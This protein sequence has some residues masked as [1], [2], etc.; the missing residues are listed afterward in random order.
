MQRLPAI[1][2]QIVSL[3][4]NGGRSLTRAQTVETVKN[5]KLTPSNG[6]FEEIRKEIEK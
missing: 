3:H 6:V 5:S 4:I 2:R 1:Q